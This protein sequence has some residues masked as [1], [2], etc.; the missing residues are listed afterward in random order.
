MVRCLWGLA[1]TI[2][3]LSN[4]ND[5]SRVGLRKVASLRGFNSINLINERQKSNMLYWFF[6]SSQSHEGSQST[7]SK[8]EVRAC[9]LGT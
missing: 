8:Y 7:I 9:V 2:W 4:C 1:Q 3:H 5:S 6:S